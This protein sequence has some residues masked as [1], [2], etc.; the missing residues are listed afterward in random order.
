MLTAEPK[1]GDG[2]DTLSRQIYRVLLEKIISLQLKPFEV[3]SEVSIA[4]EFGVSRTPTREALVRLADLG[5]VEV[6]SQR[7]TFVAPM[8]ELDLERSQFAR[9]AIETCLLERVI[10]LGRYSDLAS[11]LEVEIGIQETSARMG[12]MK[13]FCQS[14][15]AFHA[16]IAETAGY[17]HVQSEIDRA[18][19]HMDRIRHLVLKG[20]GDMGLVVDQH[21][22]I[23]M[24]VASG[25]TGRSQDALQVHLRR[26]LRLIEE[27][28]VSFPE[29]FGS[30]LQ[31]RL[32]RQR[33]RRDCLRSAHKQSV[34][35]SSP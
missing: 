29:Y 4:N 18:K 7:G 21:K 8:R 9:E 34:C 5:L 16:L 14:D 28:K 23:A 1:L 35:A 6:V 17:P 24:A 15:D 31:R 11:R 33:L 13:R 30:S 22:A 20:V 32:V 12:N 2:S 19:V 10:Q 3:L 27:A 25:E 26:V